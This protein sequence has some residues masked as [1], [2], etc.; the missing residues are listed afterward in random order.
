MTVFTKVFVEAYI[1]IKC[2]NRSRN[3]TAIA[4]FLEK[5]ILLFLKWTLFFS[6]SNTRHMR[7]FHLWKKLQVGVMVEDHQ[8]IA[9]EPT[10]LVFEIFKNFENFKSSTKIQN[11]SVKNVIFAKGSPSSW[12]QSNIRLHILGGICCRK[13]SPEQI[14]FFVHVSGW[15]SCE[16][17]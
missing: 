17:I 7:F 14:Y 12:Q 15:K 13:N 3:Y 8:S 9:F 6:F 1:Y 5:N 2:S 16:L 10:K 11:K 4:S